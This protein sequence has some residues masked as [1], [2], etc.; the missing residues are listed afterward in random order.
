M[1]VA[2]IDMYLNMKHYAKGD[3]YVLI[4]SLLDAVVFSI[5]TIVLCVCTIQLFYFLKVL[6]H[7]SRREKL[8]IGIVSCLFTT[9]FVVRF[10]YLIVQAFVVTPDCSCCVQYY[11]C[12]MF[13]YL[14]PIFD[15][16]PMLTV[17]SFDSIRFIYAPNRLDQAKLSRS[18]DEIDSGEVTD[19][20]SKLHRPSSV[21][22]SSEYGT[23]DGNSSVSPF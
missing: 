19:H 21:K 16:F 15:V 13:L 23:Y 22:S 1:I 9:S 3:H 5:L 4:F 14:L 6:R 18:I 2:S 17:L 11:D 10:V 8:L 7:T 12:L 20:D